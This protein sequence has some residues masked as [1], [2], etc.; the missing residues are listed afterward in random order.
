MF[1]EDLTEFFATSDFAVTATL[2]GTISI[3]G[4]F[5]N[6]SSPIAGGEAAVEGSIP[7][8]TCA[9]ADIPSVAQGQ[10]IL[11]NGATYTII[12][13]HPDGTGVV[14]LGLSE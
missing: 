12:A 14:T 9:M 10:T 1:T 11:I 4:I 2:A 7:T 5:A 6:A 8:F 13:V 3:A